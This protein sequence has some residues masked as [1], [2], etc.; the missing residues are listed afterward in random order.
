MEVDETVS[1]ELLD[2]VSRLLEPVTSDHVIRSYKR[3]LPEIIHH[4][5]EQVQQDQELYLLV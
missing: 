1:S 3:H 5:G 2:L 4:V